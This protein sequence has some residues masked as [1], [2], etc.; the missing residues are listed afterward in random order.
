M[1]SPVWAS[2]SDRHFGRLKKTDSIQSKSFIKLR[3]SSS[4]TS[5]EREVSACRGLTHSPS[6]WGLK[7]E[8]GKDGFIHQSAA[9]GPRAHP[10]LWK[11]VRLCGS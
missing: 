10:W 8:D 5:A 4:I 3:Y 1:L 7:G 6:V 9:G 2:C 11:K